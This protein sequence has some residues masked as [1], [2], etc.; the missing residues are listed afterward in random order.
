MYDHNI[1]LFRA[2]KRR[3]KMIIIGLVSIEW[4]HVDVEF[5]SIVKYYDYEDKWFNQIKM[6]RSKGKGFY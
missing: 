4:V 5:K 3:K 6:L 2:I 1:K